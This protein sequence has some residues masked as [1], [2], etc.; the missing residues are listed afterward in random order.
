MMFTA[1]LTDGFKDF[2]PGIG[3]RYRT[4][5]KVFKLRRLQVKTKVNVDKLRDVLFTDDC[6]LNAGSPEDMQCSMELFSTV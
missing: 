1:M 6:A 5:G 2:D 4:E 3:I